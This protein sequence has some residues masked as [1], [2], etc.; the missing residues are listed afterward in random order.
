MAA[1]TTET[2]ILS[3]FLGD[4]PDAPAAQQQAVGGA[5]LRALGLVPRDADFADTTAHGYV[6][7]LDAFAARI[8]TRG[9]HA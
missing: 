6:E 2:V 3:S 9:N 7:D 8:V 1:M 5:L 4:L